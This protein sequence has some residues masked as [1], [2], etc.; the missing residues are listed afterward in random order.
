MNKDLYEILGIN[1][2]ASEDEIKK[3]YKK[4]ALRYHPDRNPGNKE[5][6]EK[7]KEISGAYAVLSD[8]SKK[9]QYDMYGTIDG[10]NPND[11]GFS[12]EDIFKHMSGFGD[13]FGDFFGGSHFGR[14]SNSSNNAHRKAGT[15]KLQIPL[16]IYDIF[17]GYEHE[18]EYDCEM[19]CKECNGTGG[20]GIETCSHCHGTGMLTDV[21][22]TNFGIIQQSHPCQYCGGTG[23]TIKNKCHNCH[24]TG[25]IKGKKKSWV[26]FRPGVEEGEYIIINGAGCEGKE[27]TINGDLVAV[28]YYNIDNNKYRI[29]DGIVYERIDVNYYDCILGTELE[30][31]LPSHKKVK[32]KIPSYSEEGTQIVLN[33]EGINHGKYI[34]IV[35]PK[36]PK[37][38]RS[39]EREL[40]EKIKKENS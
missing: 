15:I 30:R 29:I 32:I 19:K 39:T 18:V 12:F 21:K 23:Q 27:N 20:T 2:N 7:F 1:R 38:I 13:M 8:P 25:I 16:T 36:L 3:A 24:G 28:P 26:K 10:M 4:L 6:E 22:R 14:S 17:N 40:L 31:E 5:A 35:T 37:Y 34:F 33:N 11:A 9:Q